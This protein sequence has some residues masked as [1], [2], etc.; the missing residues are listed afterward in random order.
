MTHHWM[1]P[2]AAII[3]CFSPVQK[4]FHKKIN[5]INHFNETVWRAWIFDAKLFFTSIFR[6]MKETTGL[7]WILHEFHICWCNKMHWN[8]FPLIEL[9]SCCNTIRQ[10]KRFKKLAHTDKY[11]STVVTPAIESYMHMLKK[12]MHAS[13]YKIEPYGSFET[14]TEEIA[15][16]KFRYYLLRHTP[17]WP[18]RM[19][20][21]P[22]RMLNG[23]Q[24]WFDMYWPC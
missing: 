21:W 6:L 8:Y 2:V 11:V 20:E 22:C 3:I 4:L 10:L 23:I 1:R 18:D 24:I 16:H 17:K 5:L 13:K 7:L 14:Y 12:Y 19:P 15:L 9:L